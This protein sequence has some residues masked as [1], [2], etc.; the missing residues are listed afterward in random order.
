MNERGK[1]ELLNRAIAAWNRGDLGGV[2][3]E[4]SDDFEWDMTGS[5]VPGETEVHHGR[6]GYLRFAQRWRETLGPTQLELK[7]AKELPD[8]RLFALI[9]QLATGPRSG[10]DVELHYVTIHSF[11]GDKMSRGEVFADQRKGR[12]AAGLEP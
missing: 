12:A 2:T 4:Y 11:E 8:S 1:I 9:K 10:A 6:D 3:A 5:D 7:E